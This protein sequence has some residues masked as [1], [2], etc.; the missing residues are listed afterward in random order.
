MILVVLVLAS[1]SVG[2]VS[3][4]ALPSSKL[5]EEEIRMVGIGQIDRSDFMIQ[6]P[7]LASSIAMDRRAIRVDLKKDEVSREVALV[8]GENEKRE[9]LFQAATEVEIESAKVADRFREN[10]NKWKSGWIESEEFVRDLML[11]SA[12]ARALRDLLSHIE[13]ESDRVQQMEFGGRIMTL[14]EELIPFEGPVKQYL[15]QVVKGERDAGEV[16]I[17]V[18]ERGLVLAAIRDGRYLREA[19]VWDQES[20]SR[21]MS[22]SEAISRTAEI[23][24]VAYDSEINQQT[25][26]MGKGRGYQVEIEFESGS[27]KAYLDGGTQNVFYEVQERKIG[28]IDP[29]VEVEFV[30]EGKRVVVWRS[31]VGGPAKIEITDKDTGE[32]ASAMVSMGNREKLIAKNGGWVLSPRD[33]V[34]TV[35]KI[36]GQSIDIQIDPIPMNEVENIKQD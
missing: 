6:K 30:E 23:Y 19:H 25:G 32:S 12:D 17:A 4:G 29:K 35:V 3:G 36:E 14:N 11:I 31:F 24:P 18:S 22:L 10:Q 7:N 33:G 27:I 16:Y 1:T 2:G 5:S 34:N 26:I 8:S 15:H 28:L 9:I 21:G 20:L 13:K